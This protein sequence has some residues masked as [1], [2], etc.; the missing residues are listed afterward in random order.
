MSTQRNQLKAA[1]EA[2]STESLIECARELN[3]NTTSEGMLVASMIDDVLEARMDSDSFVALM[4]EFEVQL[5]A[6]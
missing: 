4:N 5:S 1:I 3:L 2:R 6:A